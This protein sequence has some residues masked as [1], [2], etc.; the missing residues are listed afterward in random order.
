M[1]FLREMHSPLARNDKHEVTCQLNNEASMVFGFVSL[2]RPYV[3]GSLIGNPAKGLDMK[4]NHVWGMEWFCLNMFYQAL[5][6]IHY[7]KLLLKYIFW[8]ALHVG[9]NLLK[10]Q[11]C[12]RELSSK[13]T[14]MN[15]KVL[16]GILLP[17]CKS[18]KADA[19]NFKFWRS[20]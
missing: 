7:V 15:W 11:T 14:K 3:L 13:R 18:I 4:W 9:Q 2:K 20:F 16:W 10:G 12:M 5:T 1:E 19:A 8:K 17:I 6:Q